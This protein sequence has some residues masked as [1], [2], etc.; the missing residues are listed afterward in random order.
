MHCFFPFYYSSRIAQFTCWRG[1]MCTLRIFVV[2]IAYFWFN[3][4]TETAPRSSC[5]TCSPRTNSLLAR[6]VRRSRE[7]RP[8][9]MPYPIMHH[10][11]PPTPQIP[12]AASTRIRVPRFEEPYRRVISC[13]FRWC[14]Q[15]S[16]EALEDV[17]DRQFDTGMGYQYKAGDRGRSFS[18]MSMSTGSSPEGSKR[19]QRELRCFQTDQLFTFPFFSTD[20]R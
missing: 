2:H 18:R 3:P 9:W 14:F 19:R 20:A 8:I 1:R 16:V 10:H 13:D 7:R 4:N 12:A 6:L 5:K 15:D 17:T 11:P